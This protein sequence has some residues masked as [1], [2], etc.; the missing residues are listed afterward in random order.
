[1]FAT[2]KSCEIKT[3]WKKMWNQVEIQLTCCSVTVVINTSLG[4]EEQMV[5]E[6]S[7][8]GVC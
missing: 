6:S 1:M 5:A 7:T 2:G 8:R 4:C 3:V